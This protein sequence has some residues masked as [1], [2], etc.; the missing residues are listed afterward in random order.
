MKDIKRYKNNK[1]LNNNDYMKKIILFLL[2]ILLITPNLF[3]VNTFK[4]GYEIKINNQKTSMDSFWTDNLLTGD[5]QIYSETGQF[6]CNYGKCTQ[7]IYLKNTTNEK[8]KDDLYFYFDTPINNILVS[9]NEIITNK[10][11]VTDSNGQTYYANKNKGV[12]K[13]ETKIKINELKGTIKQVSNEFFT[14]YFSVPFKIDVGEEKELNL[15]FDIEKNIKGNYAVYYN[16]T[17]FLDPEYNFTELL[18]LSGNPSYVRFFQE[19]DGNMWVGTSSGD[20]YTYD[21]VNWAI[22]HNFGAVDVS[23]VEVYDDKLYVGC[24][25][26]EIY[27]Y[28]GTSWT[29]SYDFTGTYAVG[30]KVYND[31]LYFGTALGKIYVYNGTSWALSYDSTLGN[32]FSMGVY[33]G[34]LFVTGDGTGEIFT[35]DGT[36]WA[37]IYDIASDKGTY[38]EVFDGNLFIGARNSEI[39]TY[40]GTTFSMVYND[41]YDADVLGM[42]NYNDAVLFSGSTNAVGRIL[43]NI[44]DGFIVNQDLGIRIDGMGEYNNKVYVG[45]KDGYIYEWAQT[46]PPDLNISDLNI[47]YDLYDIN[48][49]EIELKITDADSNSFLI[50]LNYS[51]SNTAGTGISIIVD[52]NTDTDFI[53]T[54]NFFDVATCVYE[55]DISDM[56][57]GNY[58]ILAQ[59]EDDT[60]DTNTASSNLFEI[61][62]TTPPPQTEAEIS[63]NEYNSQYINPNQPIR[64]GNRYFSDSLLLTD[65]EKQVQELQKIGT[66]IFLVA[67]IIIPIGVLIWFKK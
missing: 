33:D 14:Y 1:T 43:Y 64:D 29:S 47:E 21:G 67:L 45:L 57:I 61:V 49:I 6:I 15:I 9:E 51:D 48:S 60:S 38:F 53:C 26:D 7:K 36:N 42:I 8:L 63:A 22:H 13:Q 25:S 50:D 10:E 3:A 44:G 65:S 30:L 19:Y 12:E 46:I 55:W 28:D 41:E 39:Y 54:G 23:G 5:L 16:D 59:I 62:D 56:N 37:S 32:I 17:S 11:L 34:N 4:K 52:A 40:D 58:Y 2:L 20:I 24:Y 18:R 66:L 35:Y 31:K 27:V